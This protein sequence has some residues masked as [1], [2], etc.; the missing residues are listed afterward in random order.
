M[1]IGKAEK[2]KG[3]GT[4]ISEELSKNSIN[5]TQSRATVKEAPTYD[6]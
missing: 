3:M 4:W 5:A 2:R 6:L 1:V